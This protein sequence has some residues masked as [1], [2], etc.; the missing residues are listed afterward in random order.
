[1]NEMLIDSGKMFGTRGW[2]THRD[3]L[4]GKLNG[5]NAMIA[6]AQK[7]GC[8]VTKEIILASGLYLPNMPR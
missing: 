3:N 7:L 2:Q 6:L 5:I 1:M 8:D 4:A